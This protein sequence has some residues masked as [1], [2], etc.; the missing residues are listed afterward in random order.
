VKTAWP[1]STELTTYA[2]GMGVTVPTGAVLADY[3]AAA[4]AEWEDATGWRPFLGALVATTRRY[5]APGSYLLDLRG[6]FTSITGVSVGLSSGDTDGSA[7]TEGTHYWPWPED[8]PSRRRP[9]WG[10]KFADA[11]HG[12][13]QSIAVTGRRGFYPTIEEDAFLAVQ[14]RAMMMI[15]RQSTGAIG[16]ATKIKQGPV[17]FTFGEGKSAAE[18][19]DAQFNETV[20]RYRRLD[21]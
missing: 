3:L 9:Y 19:L 18:V 17:E 4:I 1:T 15:L 11:Q 12:W 7:L 14:N 6:G 5:D 20:D 2:T 8:A 10:I 21:A 13:P 16:S